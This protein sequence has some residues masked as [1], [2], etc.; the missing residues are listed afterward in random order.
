[1]LAL[2]L[3]SPGMMGLGAD[4]QQVVAVV[5]ETIAERVRRI[6]AK[7]ISIGIP[8]AVG[9]GALTMLT[10]AGAFGLARSER[11]W[12][13]AIWLGAVTTVGALV[14]VA[15]A[16][17]VADDTAKAAATPATPAAPSPTVVATT[18]A[19]PAPAAFYGYY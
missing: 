7:M 4:G 19:A 9:T 2:Q 14:S 6:R 18:P 13:P 11:V 16:A 1:M 8:A 17:K 3:Q 15:L 5:T 12:A 10:F